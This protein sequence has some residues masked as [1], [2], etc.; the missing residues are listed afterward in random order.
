MADPTAFNVVIDGPIATIE[1]CS[2]QGNAFGP[3]YF[4]EASQVFDAINGNKDVRVVVLRGSG[5]TFSYGLNL[6]AMGQELMPL[7]QQ[8]GPKERQKL[9]AVIDNMQKS[10]NCIAECRVPVIAAVHNWCIGAGLDLVSAADIRV[11]S[12][13]AQFSLRE[14]KVAMVADV[15]SLQRLPPI[16]GEGWTRRM[17]LTGEDVDAET[18]LR[19]GLV[20]E[21]LDDKDA[22][23]TRAQNLAKAIADNPPLVVEGIKDVMNE[24]IEADI[25]RGLRYVKQH[26]SAYLPSLDLGEALASFFEKRPPLY[27]GE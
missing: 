2:P 26:N 9:A 17:A 24:R 20:S 6:P 19:I 21:V 11:C 27:K 1:L 3:D 23:F 16:I 13:D 7:L 8:P 5:K 18:A 12:A 15:G 25:Q 10:I 4:N 14:V 22:C